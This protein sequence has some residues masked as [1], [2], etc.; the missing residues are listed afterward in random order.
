MQHSSA[1]QDLHFG[2]IL[3]CPLPPG[4][5]DDDDFPTVMSLSVAKAESVSI[6]LEN[7]LPISQAIRWNAMKP[8]AGENQNTCVPDCS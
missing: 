6:G 8:M 4:S 3:R 5:G 2:A 1:S 7:A